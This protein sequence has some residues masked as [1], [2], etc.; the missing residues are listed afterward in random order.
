MSKL[1]PQSSQ[2]LE[3]QESPESWVGSGAVVFVAVAVKVEKVDDRVSGVAEASSS[4]SDG[5]AVVSESKELADPEAEGA[6]VRVVFLQD[7]V[8][9]LLDEEDD[10][11]RNPLRSVDVPL[12]LPV[13]DASSVVCGFELLGS[14]VLLRF[15]VLL[16]SVS[17]GFLVF[18]FE[19]F[20]EEA[21]GSSF[22]DLETF[23]EDAGA[24]GLG[25]DLGMALDV[26]D[27]GFFVDVGA[28]VG[29]G[30]LVFVFDASVVFVFLV[31]LAGLGSATSPVFALAGPNGM[32]VENRLHSLA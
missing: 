31:L 27:L 29:A 32:H 5:V 22:S 26:V 1:S 11:E 24:V 15:D 12:G 23:V 2:P 8:L 19:V 20:R 14:S 21:V 10:E 16:V 4:L 18:V 17:E 13:G 9:K 3:V 28:S 25:V 7:R 6:P 30:V